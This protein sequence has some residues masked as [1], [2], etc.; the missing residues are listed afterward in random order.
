[1]T[2]TASDRAAATARAADAAAKVAKIHEYYRVVDAGNIP[3]L[4]PL[5]ATDSVYRRP[6]Y[7]PMRGL[8]T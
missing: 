6:G 8:A 2:D 5:F 7:A 3:A 1:M 4:V